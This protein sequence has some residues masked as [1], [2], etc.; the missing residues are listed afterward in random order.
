MISNLVVTVFVLAGAFFSLLAAI[1]VIRFPDVYTRMHAA[2][3]APAFGILLF[4]IAAVFFFADLYTT[5]ISLMIVVFIFLTAPVASHIIS[6]VAHLLNT[7]IWSKTI[8]DEL[9][10]DTGISR[11][12]LPEELSDTDNH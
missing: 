1:G 12:K 9:A 7:E 5:A 3:K 11:K 6:R 4:L 8:I 2:T 10:N